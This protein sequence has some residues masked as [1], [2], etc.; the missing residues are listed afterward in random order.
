MARPVNVAPG[1]LPVVVAGARPIARQ[2]FGAGDQPES[3]ARQLQQLQQQVD[4]ATQLARS[5]AA[6]MYIDVLVDV[7]GQMLPPIRHQLNRRPYWS[8][9]DWVPTILGAPFA[10]VRVPSAQ[11][12]QLLQLQA[13]A[14]GRATIKVE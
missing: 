5:L 7:A 12:T 9:V 11:D 14:L 2:Q 8:V 1:R 4:Q 13:F 10:F 3:R 6:P